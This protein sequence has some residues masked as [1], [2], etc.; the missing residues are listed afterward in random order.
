MPEVDAGDLTRRVTI[1]RPVGTTSATGGI[2]TGEPETVLEQWPVA[3]DPV[4]VSTL[5]EALVGGQVIN[6]GTTIV[7][8]RYHPAVAVSQQVQYA[9]LRRGTTRTLEVLALVNPNEAN[10]E[11]QLLCAERTT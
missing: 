4:G 11:L 10:V 6:I 2:V 1:I 7:R 3:M 5:A 9:D 8:M